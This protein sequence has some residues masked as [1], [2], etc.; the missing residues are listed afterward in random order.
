MDDKTFTS[1]E[2]RLKRTRAHLT[3]VGRLLESVCD[4]YELSSKERSSLKEVR[5]KVREAYF[6]LLEI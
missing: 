1:Y 6:D 4:E 2:R 3:E 5:K